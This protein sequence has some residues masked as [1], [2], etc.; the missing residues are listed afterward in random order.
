MHSALRS[1]TE[2]LDHVHFHEREVLSAAAT[3]QI[4]KESL[5]NAIADLAAATSRIHAASQSP[6]EQEHARLQ[7]MSFEEILR[8]MLGDMYRLL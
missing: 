5:A 4:S 2:Q 1:F 8:E 6:A 3:L 7:S